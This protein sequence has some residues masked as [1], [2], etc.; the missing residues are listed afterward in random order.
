MQLAYQ[1]HNAIV[2]PHTGYSLNSQMMFWKTL[3]IYR[4]H[5]IVNNVLTAIN[6]MYN[7]LPVCTVRRQTQKC[8]RRL[9]RYNTCW[10]LFT[11]QLGHFVTLTVI[12]VFC[13]DFEEKVLE[14]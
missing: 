12:A 1:Y 6:L 5:S 14:V 2:K 8:L 4:G 13:A 9:S 11:L 7:D 3:N 10:L